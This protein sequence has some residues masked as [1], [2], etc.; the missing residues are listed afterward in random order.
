MTLTSCQCEHTAHI[1]ER[2]M[3]P[4][5]NP[6]HRYGV[7]FFDTNLTTVKTPYGT[8]RVCRDC[9]ADCFQDIKGE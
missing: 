5:G 3:T 7:N 9:R 2:A 1:A 8:F 6:G 4:N